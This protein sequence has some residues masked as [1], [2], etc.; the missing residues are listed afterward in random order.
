MLKDTKPTPLRQ[1]N[2]RFSASAD[3]MMGYR[4]RHRRST[5]GIGGESTGMKGF[6]PS[7]QAV[8]FVLEAREA[9]AD[10]PP[11]LTFTSRRLN[12]DSVEIVR[13]AIGERVVR[14]V[15][16]VAREAA[17]REPT[18]ERLLVVTTEGRFVSAVELGL[19]SRL[20]IAPHA[21]KYE[22]AVRSLATELRNWVI[23]EPQ[24]N[25]FG[26]QVDASGHEVFIQ[27]PDLTPRDPFVRKANY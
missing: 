19:K 6:L 10:V 23:H 11:Q 7:N 9:P 8:R 5:T 12:G 25:F 22:Q 14:L 27:C 13:E 4:L 18:L 17:L 26:L 20:G 2:A 3:R 16:T 24:A 1:Q 21:T 15:G